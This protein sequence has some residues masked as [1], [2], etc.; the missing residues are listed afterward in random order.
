[1]KLGLDPHQRSVASQLVV[2]GAL[3]KEHMRSLQGH[4]EGV[5]KN[6]LHHMRR[7]ELWKRM[8]YGGHRSDPAKPASMQVCEVHGWFL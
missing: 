4:F 6:A 3:I 5:V 8:L 1:M 2:G 7:D